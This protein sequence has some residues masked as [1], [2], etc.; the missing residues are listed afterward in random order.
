MS[1][2]DARQAIGPNEEDKNSS[3]VQSALVPA[4]KTLTLLQW[5]VQCLVNKI[6]ILGLIAAQNYCDVLSLS[7]HWLTEMEM[8]NIAIPGFCVASYFCR[9]T[10][11]HGGSVILVKEGIQFLSCE[12]PFIA[13]ELTFEMSSIRLPDFK[14]VII[15]FYRPPTGKLL[16]FFDKLHAVITSL[17]SVD[18]NIIIAGDFNL[19]F[20]CH[21]SDLT[22]LKNLFASF[23]LNIAVLDVTRPNLFSGN[24]AGSCIDNVVTSVHSDRWMTKVLHV[25]ASDHN[26]ILFRVSL[27]VMN[28]LYR[29]IMTM[30]RPI[31]TSNSRILLHILN[32]LNWL[33]IYDSKLDLNSKC[34]LF[35][36]FLLWAVDCS[37]PLNVKSMKNKKPNVKWYHEGLSVLKSDLDK[38][39]FVLNNSANVNRPAIL[40][41]YKKAKKHYK[42]EVRNAK[43]LYNNQTIYKSTNRSKSIWSLINKSKKGNSTP[44]PTPVDLPP[45][46]FNKYFVECI[47]NIS[48]NIPPSIKHHSYYLK[49]CDDVY[50]NRPAF[51]FREFTVEEVFKTINDLSNSSC[52]DFYGLNSAILKLCSSHIC[53]V[54]TFLFN[55]CVAQSIFPDI[56]KLSKVIPVHKKGPKHQCSNYRPISIIPI[57]S[58]VLERLVHKQIVSFLEDN[59]LFSERQFGFRPNQSTIKAVLSLVNDCYDGL[60]NRNNI[61]FRSFDMSKAFDTVDHGVL[62]DKLLFYLSND[63]AVNFFKSYLTNR[64]QTVYVNGT[65]SKNLQVMNGVPQGSI[66][67]PTL[68]ILYINDL[69]INLSG[70]NSHCFIFADDLGLN[71][72]ARSCAE[73]GSILENKTNIVQDWCHANKLCLNAEKVQ[74]LTLNLQKPRGENSV[75]KFLG[76]FV[77]SDLKWFSHI[78]NV[79]NKLAK[80]L[81]M[82]RSLVGSVSPDILLCIYY[83]YIHSHLSYGIQLWGNVGYSKMIFVLQKKAIRLICGVPAQTHCKPLFISL[84]VLSLPSMYILSVLLYIKL[85]LNMFSTMADTHEHNTRHRNNITIKRCV[86]SSTQNSFEYQGIMMYNALPE[87]V[88]ELPLNKFKMYL[89]KVLTK[90]CIYTL[91][92]FY[93]LIRTAL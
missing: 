12:L 41:K 13:E 38:L 80:G 37:M 46:N 50:P 87:N 34:V 1:K 6:D 67:G 36:D 15:S 21:S 43:L 78:D 84:G 40:E 74:D 25:G 62:I 19:D 48:H 75:L 9:T 58:K 52:L 28:R 49:K 14:T 79:S 22:E 63:S 76:I 64:Q 57:V 23:G 86:F 56:F 91:S 42:N 51:M 73:A 39:Y 70:L 53:E 83:A 72:R 32:K 60:E 47:E 92:E 29:P 54:L 59:K 85:N 82:I 77:Q 89:K 17:Y 65:F 71:I 5:N 45:D 88:K 10:K 90:N 2:C 27:E 24:C 35:F 3:K 66:L 31:N 33:D 16:S 7:E 93:T 55:Q 44:L 68:F 18:L 11:R 69:P 4:T 30:S 26:P 61:V 20:L 81:F 8:Q